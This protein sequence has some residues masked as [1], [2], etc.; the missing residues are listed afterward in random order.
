MTDFYQYTPY[1]PTNGRLYG[2]M[3]NI[4]LRQ[5]LHDLLF[6]GLDLYRKAGISLSVR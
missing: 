2:N 3:T 6:G 5:E 4:D 1:D